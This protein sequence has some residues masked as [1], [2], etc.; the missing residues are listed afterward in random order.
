MSSPMLPLPLMRTTMRSK[1]AGH[2]SAWCIAGLGRLW[3]CTQ[4][5]ATRR[6]PRDFRSGSWSGS[7]VGGRMRSSIGPWGLSVQRLLA[8]STSCA[9]SWAEAAVARHRA[10]ADSATRKRIRELY[11]AP[12]FGPREAGGGRRDPHPF[13]LEA[14]MGD[15]PYHPV[16][17]G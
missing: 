7:K 12:S 8:C 11:L 1:T 4:Y 14:S 5:W 2:F 13:P 17:L 16:L 6:A 9:A 10:A 3:H 15:P